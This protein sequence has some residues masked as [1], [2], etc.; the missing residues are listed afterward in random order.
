[1]RTEAAVS[2]LRVEQVV[3]A[4][5][6]WTAKDHLTALSFRIMHMRAVD[7]TLGLLPNAATAVY[8][9]L[10]PGQAVPETADL[11]AERLIHEASRWLS[12]WL[13]SSARAGDDIALRFACSWYEGLDLNALHSLRD[14]TPTNNDPTLGAT[15]RAR[16]YE[17]ASY[18]T[19]S[20]FIPPPANL[21]EVIND[22][23]EEEEEGIGEGNDEAEAIVPEAPAAGAPEPTAAAPETQA[24]VNPEPAR[25]DSAPLY[26]T[27]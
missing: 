21:K 1:V 12:E 4:N 9:C 17:I 19:T 8:K 27:P 16:A 15:R 6:P 20:D 10:W 14:D 5:L 18:T 3:D 13:H 7:H 23:A 26:Q 22:E 2:K 25:E 11:V 24:P